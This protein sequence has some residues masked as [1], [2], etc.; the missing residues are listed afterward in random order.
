MT[1]AASALLDVMTELDDPGSSV[2]G[3]DLPSSRTEPRVSTTRTA[4]AAA[5]LRDIVVAQHAFIWRTMRRF[6]VPDGRVD[7]AVSRVFDVLARRLAEIPMN[8]EQAFLLNVC[9]RVASEFRRAE[10]RRVRLEQPIREAFAE[11]EVRSVPSPE[12]LLDRKQ[13]RAALSAALDE[14]TPEL[15]AVLVLHELEQM[16]MA[17]IA[18]ALGVPP[19]TVASRLRRARVEFEDA[20]VRTRSRFSTIGEGR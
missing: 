14:L 13:A 11:E 1:V 4:E 10:A 12:D 15:R 3:D 20:A 17:E 9:V 18:E 19:G 7:D 8:K 2:D 5:R 6:G 16:T